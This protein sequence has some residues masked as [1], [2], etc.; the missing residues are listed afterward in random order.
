MAII[1]LT[2][3]HVTKTCSSKVNFKIFFQAVA[4]VSPTRIRIAGISSPTYN[5]EV[6]YLV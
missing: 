3:V 2:V 1:E 4:L 5:L 6:V